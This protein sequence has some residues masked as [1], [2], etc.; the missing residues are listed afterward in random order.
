MTE[1]RRTKNEPPRTADGF[2]ARASLPEYEVD[3]KRFK[4]VN[5]LCNYLS[6][7]HDANSVSAVG[8]D[9]CIRVSS[10]GWSTK[11]LKATYAVSAPE[12]GKTMQLTLI[13][14]GAS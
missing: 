2:R 8:S 13:E 10:V 5:G 7:K 4:T 1:I 9:R 3:G 14:R 6:K 12:I 11:I